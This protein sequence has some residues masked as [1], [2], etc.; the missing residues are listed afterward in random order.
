MVQVP[1]TEEYVRSAF[2]LIAEDRHSEFFENYVRPDIE[3]IV[4]GP[5]NP[6]A[7]TFTS[8][9][10]FQKATF[11]EL[12]GVM[13]GPYR[14]HL[15]NVILCRDSPSGENSRVAIVELKA[16]CVTLQG[17]PYPQELCWIITFDHDGKMRK[18]KSYLDGALVRK[19]FAAAGKI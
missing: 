3:W 1:I 11:E 16:D 6:V 7:G 9:A 12:H 14:M 8:R 15:L 18:I 4:S 10:A 2:N 5:E 19:I 17:I 13:E